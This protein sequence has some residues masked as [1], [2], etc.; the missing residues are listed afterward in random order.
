MR[1]Q[2][3]RD[4]AHRLLRVVR[5]VGERDPCPRDELA[6]AKASMRGAWRRSV[7]EP[8]D[9][10]DED[11]RE[12]RSRSPATRAPGRMTFC[13]MPDHSRLLSSRTGRARRRRAPP[14]RAWVELDGRPSHQVMR[15]QTI[16]PSSAASTVFSVAR[17]VSIEPLPDRLRDRR[18]HERAREVRRGGDEHRGAARARA[19]R[20]TSRRSSRCRGSRS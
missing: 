20:P 11:E 2:R 7:E 13:Q 9:E 4:H 14:T 12:R 18:R 6:V 10:D 5:A 3:E 17:P 1:V 16:A 8:V 15:F 19:C